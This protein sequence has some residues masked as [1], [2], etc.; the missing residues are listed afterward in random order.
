VVCVGMFFYCLAACRSNIFKYSHGGRMAQDL[1]ELIPYWI[2]EH[3]IFGNNPIAIPLQ[4]LLQRLLGRDH[5]T[6]FLLDGTAFHCMS[7]QKYFFVRDKY[8]H[9]IAE[10]FFE[11]LKPNGVTYDIGANYG[12]WAIRA[13]VR[14]QNVI[15]FEPS[16]ENLVWLRK[17]IQNLPIEI[18]PAAVS[19]S[20]GSIEINECGSMTSMG[21]G[22][23]RVECVTL[24]SL[25]LRSPNMILIDVEG[26]AGPVLKGARKLIGES[27][28]CL[29]VELHHDEERNAVAEELSPH[30]YHINPIGQNLRYPFHIVADPS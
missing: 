18:V 1:V 15:A 27:K 9:H 25:S 28:P 6:S 24:D 2:S 13:A 17:N 8:E 4:K 23:T 16:P 10:A 5:E 22:S 26:F 20:N 29:L 11:R 12:F 30:G 7:S 14:G 3:V 21:S 19:E